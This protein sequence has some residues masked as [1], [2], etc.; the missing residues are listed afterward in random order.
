M[1]RRTTPTNVGDGP[2]DPSVVEGVVRGL[3]KARRNMM[4]NSDLGYHDDAD[5]DPSGRRMMYALIG[6]GLLRTR[7]PRSDRQS[8]AS[9]VTTRLGTAVRQAIVD[10]DARR[11][12]QRSASA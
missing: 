7:D 9:Y 11:N 4:K 5:L 6:L 10:E 3:T 2:P 8:C 12:A 1:T